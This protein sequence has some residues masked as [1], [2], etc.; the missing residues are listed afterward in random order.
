M[1]SEKRRAALQWTLSV[2]ALSFLLAVGFQFAWR[3]N[4]GSTPKFHR[5]PE[6]QRVFD[7]T[8]DLSPVGELPAT[9]F[10]NAS[11]QVAFIGSQAC[12]EC[13]TEQSAGR[14]QTGHSRA[15]REI[16][17]AEEP[18]DGSFHHQVSGRSYQVF[19]RD[20][21]M[22]HSESLR[23]K[24]GTDVLLAEYPIK[25]LVGS[26]Q[27][28]RTYLIEDHGFLAESPI[29]WYASVNAW[30]LS[31][32]FDY[33]RPF[34]FQ[35]SVDERC[36]VCHVGR[37]SRQEQKLPEVEIHE[38]GISC[39]RCHGPGA[40]HAKHWEHGK[41]TDKD[42][43][44]TI[45][46]PA[47]LPREEQE[48]ICAQ[49]HLESAAFVDVRGRQWHQ[50]R[51]GHALRYFVAHYRLDSSE[52]Q[53]KVVGHVE[54]LRQSRCYQESS[55][56]TCTT[57]HKSHQAPM[58]LRQTI[59]WHCKQCISCHSEPSH[60][61]LCRLSTEERKREGTNDNC[62]TC[63]MPRSPT[64]APHV[65]STLHRIGLHKR[66]IPQAHALTEAVPLVPVEDL[67]Y[68]SLV[69]RERSLGLAYLVFADSEDGSRFRK[70]Y[71][72]R[73]QGLLE[74][75][76]AAGLADASVHAALAQLEFEKGDIQAA[77]RSVRLALQDS[78]RLSPH[79]RLSTERFLAQI[80]FQRSDFQ[81]A[82]QILEQVVGQRRVADDWELLGACKKEMGD[83]SGAL[84]AVER[85][86]QINPDNLVLAWALVELSKLTNDVSRHH[87]FRQ[88]AH[89]LD[90][91]SRALRH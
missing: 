85:A 29:S 34:G 51:P 39:E 4:F 28:A 52:D 7:H 40:L 60:Q 46:H 53:L 30:Q 14:S 35:R 64:E 58:T 54:Q 1:R 37:V 47:R 81:S 70:I 55:T 23:T 33:P 18:P 36:L 43:D 5:P 9:Q 13:H 41:P 90:P 68:M 87:Q 72:A 11:E 59:E 49:C 10:E 57:C 21:Q 44:F 48:S 2:C 61:K 45:V 50:F 25:Y 20:G 84:A 56:L 67:S 76:Q 8:G 26:G 69:D 15:F 19:R 91:S 3:E 73:A 74:R 78:N 86:A 77:S 42:A 88:R 24:A 17:E 82:Q 6:T 80:Y 63:H 83:V 16:I 71:L 89:L 27:L 79:V 31:P 65:A 66:A 22:W 12:G 62:V 75:L 32:G 38:Q